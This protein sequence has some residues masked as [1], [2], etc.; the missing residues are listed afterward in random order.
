[1]RRT[2]FKRKS[3]DEVK[4]TQALKRSKRPLGAS[5]LPRPRKS[6]KSLKKKSKK[7]N[8]SKLKKLLWQECRRLTLLRY[9]EPK[10][11]TCGKFGITGSNCHLGHFIP[12]SICSVEMRYSL[13]NLR[14]QCY[15]CNI[16][17]SGNWPAYEAHLM[18]EKGLDFPTLLKKR[19]EETKNKQ[20]DSLW[21]LQ[22][23]EEYKNDLL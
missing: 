7:P 20:Y 14:F 18:I 11:Y 9:P 1:M 22:K 8:I 2:G 5:K 23:L 19:N 6:T 13:D 21:Y 10:C 3:L 15:S 17:K 4:A 12:S 16:H